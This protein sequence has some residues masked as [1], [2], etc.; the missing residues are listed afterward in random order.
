MTARSD[1]KGLRFGRLIA[2]ESFSEF[3]SSGKRYR[4]KW[5]CRCDC[6][7][8]VNVATDK[9]SSGHTKSC[10]CLRSDVSRQTATTHG[11]TNHK[12][13][14]TWE[15]MKS[16]CYKPLNDNYKYY[17]GRGIEVCLEWRE[18]FSKFYEW[19]MSNGW[20]SEL[21][22]DRIDVNGDYCPENCRWVT[23]DVQRNNRRDIMQITAFGDTLTSSQWQLCTGVPSRTIIWR[24]RNGWTPEDAVSIPVRRM[25][26]NETKSQRLP[27]GLN[28][29]NLPQLGKRK[30]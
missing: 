2:L 20:D 18:D 13:Y 15:S 9:L 5:R 23:W 3:D 12:L 6:G 10:G 30:P 21:T 22:L 7:T 8:I 17:G 11:K 19:A 27:E 1:L 26:H 24:I 4:T 14:T 28:R 25:V 29:Q 16:R